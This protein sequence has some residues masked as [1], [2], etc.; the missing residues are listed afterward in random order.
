MCLEH[1]YLWGIEWESLGGSNTKKY[2][3]NIK[4]IW[5]NIETSIPD[6]STDRQVSEFVCKAMSILPNISRKWNNVS[7]EIPEWSSKLDIVNFIDKIREESNKI[8]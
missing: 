1:K 6:N 2:L 3:L 4:Q 5:N 7:F 8:F